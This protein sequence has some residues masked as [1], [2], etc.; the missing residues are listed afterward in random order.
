MNRPFFK[1]EEY[2]IL[3][4]EE[5]TELNG[6]CQVNKLFGVIKGINEKGNVIHGFAYELTTAYPDPGNTPD[7]WYEEDIKKLHASS[8]FSFSELIVELNKKVLD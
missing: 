2:V 6:V 1:T 8:V 7:C 4:S 5:Y 3:A